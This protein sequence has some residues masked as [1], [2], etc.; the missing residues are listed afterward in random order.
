MI[1][2]KKGIKNVLKKQIKFACD[3]EMESLKPGNV[4]KYRSGHNMNVK[5]FLKSSLIISRCITNNK[6]N[7]GRK[8]LRSVKE[9]KK[10]YKKKYKLRNNF[11]VVSN[12]NC[13]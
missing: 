13:Y 5:D 1:I 4:H 2:K 3:M 12:C 9:T 7:L 8:I 11:N 6:S 10:K